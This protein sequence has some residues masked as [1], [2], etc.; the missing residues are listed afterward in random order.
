M[1]LMQ[2]MAGPA[3]AVANWHPPRMMQAAGN[4][5]GQLLIQVKMLPSETIYN[6][7]GRN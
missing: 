4:S 7:A 3:G 2:V 5:N 6:G 1:A